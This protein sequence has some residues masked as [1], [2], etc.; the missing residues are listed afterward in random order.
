MH[1]ATQKICML[2]VGKEA[3]TVSTLDGIANCLKNETR[4]KIVSSNPCQ[5]PSA[6]TH[7]YIRSSLRILFTAFLETKTQLWK[8]VWA[9]SGCCNDSSGSPL[10]PPLIY[11]HL[12]YFQFFSINYF[13]GYVSIIVIFIIIIIINLFQFDLR[14][15]TKWKNNMNN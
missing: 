2:V 8:L 5:R 12:K 4:R 7:N 13:N 15:S 14:N 9:I 11:I 3:N 6:V 1:L 10:H